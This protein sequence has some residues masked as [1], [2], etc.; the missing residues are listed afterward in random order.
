M[1]KL[2]LA[3]QDESLRGLLSVL[4][5]GDRPVAVLFGMRS[6]RVLH[7]WVAAYD[8]QVRR[9]SPGMQLWTALLRA[10]PRYGVARIDLGKGDEDYKRHLGNGATTVG[11]GAI[12]QS[13]SRRAAKFAWY[14]IHQRM[15]ASPLRAPL[16]TPWR[17]V[18]R[19]L[20]QRQFK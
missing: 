7:S 15:R 20:H 4:Y 13:S 12:D 18:K 10:A 9:V 3:R 1:F 11:E 8:T 6:H 17:M 14:R 16:T 5:A 19:L 2:L